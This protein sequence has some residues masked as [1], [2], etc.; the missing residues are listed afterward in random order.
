MFA[1][2]LLSSPDGHPEM[3]DT[4]GAL[5]LERSRFH[6]G[7]EYP[8][9]IR[10][11]LNLIPDDRLWWRP[12]ET[13]NSAA[14]L[15]LHLAGNI[16]QWMVSG[17]GGAVDQRQRDREFEVP[18]D[19][20]ETWPRD[21]LV[22]QLDAACRDAVAVLAGLDVAALGTTRI[23]QGRETSVLAAI[24]HVVEHC[25]GHTGQIIQIAKWTTPGGVRFY[26]DTDG[27]ARPLFLPDGSSDIA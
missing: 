24:Y 18:L 15:V 5:F 16:R 11:S 4:I 27:L 14:N 17:V 22:E 6:L 20:R 21:R 9:K 25:S 8:A 1:P 26:D 3:S 13:S 10:A 19:A 2:S 12:N 23:I 7:V